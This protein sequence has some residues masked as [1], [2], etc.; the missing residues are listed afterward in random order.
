MSF[1]VCFNFFAAVSP[2]NPPPMI[3]IF[4]L[5]ILFIPS[6][7]IVQDFQLKGDMEFFSLKKQQ[8]LLT[9]FIDFKQLTLR[10]K[11]GKRR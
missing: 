2:P 3:T 9:M 10:K 8:H 4:S 7:L 11:K 1:L 6:E 5:S